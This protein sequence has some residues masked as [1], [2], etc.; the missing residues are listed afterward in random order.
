MLLFNNFI[1]KTKNNSFNK[2][3]AILVFI[4]LINIIITNKLINEELID[5]YDTTIN[6]ILL[7]IFIFLYVFIISI[8][9]YNIFIVKKY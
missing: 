3:I 4:Y 9:I 1:K 5:I 7:R 8:I 6:K 2:K